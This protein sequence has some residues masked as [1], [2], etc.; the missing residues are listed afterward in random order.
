ML[1]HGS[2]NSLPAKHR[3]AL[4]LSTAFLI[5]TLLLSGLP[6]FLPVSPSEHR[7]QLSVE[8][9]ATGSISGGPA[10]DPLDKIETRNPPFEITPHTPIPQQETPRVTTS[11]SRVKTTASEKPQAATLKNKAAPSRATAISSVSGAPANPTASKQ[12]PKTGTTKDATRITQSP[13]EQDPYL[14]K[15]A[16]HLAAKLETSRIPA[17]REL[18]DT[19]TMELELQLLSNGAL[20]R[21][22]VIK[23]TGAGQI[24]RAAYQAA[25][26]ASPYPEPPPD[27]SSKSHFEVKLVFSPSRL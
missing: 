1:E 15:L 11:H 17:L 14:I 21:A 16:M 24:D 19:T 6:S 9:V 22:R 25:L 2:N 26:S 10:A 7:Q 20:T 8:L 4:A 5:H 13:I 3:I 18:A 12:V 23:S 27:Q